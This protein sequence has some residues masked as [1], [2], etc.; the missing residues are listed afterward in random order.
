M[1]IDE[2]NAINNIKSTPK[3]KNKQKNKYPASKSMSKKE[4]NYWENKRKKAYN[5]R[6]WP[7]WRENDGKN[8][9]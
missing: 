9:L 4:R 8:H 7:G 6:V 2:L 3:K 5:D 1:N